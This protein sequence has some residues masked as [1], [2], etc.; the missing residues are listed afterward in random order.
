MFD[1]VQQCYSHMLFRLI[2]HSYEWGNNSAKG[3]HNELDP[4][5]IVCCSKVEADKAQEVFDK[6]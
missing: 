4:R 1:N 2:T 6:K 5:C 3:L